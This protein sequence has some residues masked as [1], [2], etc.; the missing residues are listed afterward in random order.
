MVPPGIAQSTQVLG[1]ASRGGRR[2]RGY[3]VF[4][5]M[6]R[7]G[8]VG[9]DAFV[10]RFCAA[11]AALRALAADA[12]P[13]PDVATLRPFGA[14]RRQRCSP[15]L[16]LKISIS[17]GMG[18]SCQTPQSHRRVLGSRPVDVGNRRATVLAVPNDSQRTRLARTPHSRASSA[19]K[20]TTGVARAGHYPDEFAGLSAN[21]TSRR[22]EAFSQDQA[23]I[24]LG[25][26][27][28]NDSPFPANRTNVPSFVDD[29][30]QC[31][32]PADRRPQTCSQGCRYPRH[33]RAWNRPC[34]TGSCRR[35]CRP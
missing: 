8:A 10:I 7:L 14:T 5:R 33:G 20:R 4:L 28:N 17:S 9:R 31:L 1:A 25:H 21:R 19:L 26:A 32:N 3:F 12:K 27:D 22:S 30:C 24:R 18:R 15:F 16:S 13:S 2:R 35:R 11:A 34:P 29:R 6:M 23:Q